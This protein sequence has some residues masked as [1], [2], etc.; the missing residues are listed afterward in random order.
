MGIGH[1]MG[2]WFI[3][4]HKSNS[5]QS[6][7]YVGVVGRPQSWGQ[8]GG[9]RVKLWGWLMLSITGYHF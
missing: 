6:E 8:N 2:V 1:W 9:H 3:D 4:Y 7:H 5:L